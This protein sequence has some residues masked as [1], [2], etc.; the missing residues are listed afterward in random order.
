M[1]VALLTCVCL[2]WD[3]S[4]LLFVRHIHLDCQWDSGVGLCLSMQVSYWR[5]LMLG[6]AEPLEEPRLERHTATHCN[7]L[8]HTVTQCTEL[9]RTATRWNTIQCFSHATGGR[10]SYF[11]VGSDFFY[12]RTT[13]RYNFFLWQHCNTLQRIA[14]HCNTLQHTTAHWNTFLILQLPPGNKA[15]GICCIALQRTATH[16]NTLQHTAA[17][18]NALTYLS[19]TAAT[20]KIAAGA[21]HCDTLQ[22]TATH[23]NTLQHTATHCFT[24]QHTAVHCNKRQHTEFPF[25]YCS[26]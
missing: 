20:K 1:C 8:H 19:D 10:I 24:L 13:W 12:G 14:T 6:G 26:H 15:G 7:A 18:C 23:C 2:F 16:R 17:H 25:S 22:H 3:V 9:Q 4:V 21:T 5:V 11:F